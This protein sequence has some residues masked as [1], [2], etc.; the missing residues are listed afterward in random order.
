MKPEFPR[1]DLNKVE[2]D[3]LVEF[4]YVQ[5]WEE[6]LKHLN[7]NWEVFEELEHNKFIMMRLK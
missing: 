5:G 4:K 1:T 6:M 7:E 2:F 3:E